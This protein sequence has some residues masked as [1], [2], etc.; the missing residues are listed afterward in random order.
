MNRY[1]KYIL[2]AI[3]KLIDDGWDGVEYPRDLDYLDYFEGE[4]DVQKKVPKAET[5]N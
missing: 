4:F 5:K 3:K 1:D 2:E